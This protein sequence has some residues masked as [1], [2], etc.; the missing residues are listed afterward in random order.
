MEGR[1]RIELFGQL[2]VGRGDAAPLPLPR[3][4]ATALLAYLAYHTRHPHAR[5]GL[6]DLLWPEADLEEGR[7]NLRRQLH[8]LRELLA[9]PES[10]AGALLL[11]ERTTVQLDPAMFTTDVAEFHAALRAAAR[12]ADLT[13]RLRALEAA[14]TLYRGELLP[15]SYEG[16]V[17]TERQALAERYLGALRELAA[18]REAA[19]DLEGALATAREA[20]SSDPLQEEAHYDVMRLCAALGQPTA[21]LRQ[22][23]ELERVLREEL[24]E[25]PSAEAR[26]LAEELR[27]SARTL[28]VARRSSPLLSPALPAAAPPPGEPPEAAPPPRG[29]PAPRLPAQ[30]TRFFGREEETAWLVELLAAGGTRL[31]TLTGP[32]G[33]G[34]TRLAIAVA[35][36]LEALFDEA[37]AVASLVDLG[38]AGRLMETIADALELPRSPEVEP[39][40]QVVAHLQGRPWLLVLDNF[41][42]LVEGGATQVRT[43][44][45]QVESLVCLVTS[46]Q[47]LGLSGERELALLPLPT[48]RRSDP[49]E[50]VREYASVQLFGDRARAVRADFQLTEANASAVGEL[51]DR[52]EGLPLALELAG[53][54]AA[55]LSP[56]EMLG[57]LE[58]RFAFLVSRRRDVS[59]RHR[60][61]RAAIE[62]SYQLLDPE[63]RQFFAR[64]SVFRGGFT[65]EAAHAVCPSGAGAG[66]DPIRAPAAGRRT[67]VEYLEQLRECSL[68]GVEE[69]S[70]ASRYRLLE[71][72]REYG[73]EQLA[74]AGELA[75]T[76][77]RHREWYLQLAEQADAEAYELEVMPKGWLT[78][79]EAELENLRAALGWC[80]EEAE[81]NPA[82]EGAEAGLRLA[83]A[84]C[85][86]WSGRGNLT[87]G[88]QWLEA[89]LARGSHLPASVRGP[90]LLRAA[91]LERRGRERW[92]SFVQAARREYEQVLNL[93][94]R[95]GNLSDIAHSLQ[96]LAEVASDDEDFEAAWSYC[97]EARQLFDE[98]GEPVGIARTLGWMAGIALRRGELRAA[99][100][101]LE[102]R[103]AICRTLGDPTLLVHALGGMGHLERNE[104]DYAC[105]Q[106]LYQ[107][108][109]LLRR[110]LGALF[111]LAQSLED[112][113]VLAGRQRQTER[114]IRLL[115]AAEA[116]CETLGA[117][118]PVAEPAEYERTVTEGRAVLGEAVF[119]AV[120]AAGRVM[121][122]EQAIEYALE[123]PP[124]D[125]SPS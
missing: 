33:S 35:G 3:Q 105:A 75:A 44:L 24:A 47:V 38:D 106:A 59:P 101:L 110:E 115:G 22:Y 57:E 4:K 26:A 6:I 98:L 91:H 104:G 30:L 66:S 9:G 31:V 73:W 120:W 72:L 36:R 123:D 1:W 32:G 39:F 56:Q 99:R 117:R 42:Q 34:K 70:G 118:P 93:A 64:L 119:A 86:L 10:D 90:A 8:L 124:G 125:T 83:A 100:P 45:E 40:V 46:R 79:L 102:E 61:L 60:T 15:G 29:H 19:G 114:A 116:F 27:Q 14:V 78:R 65:L 89:M 112:L 103:L 49:L 111:A 11:A 71:T 94:R 82:G 55:V 13:E 50:R 88:L 80:Q 122:L 96:S 62:S 77:S 69:R 17:L 109:L 41:E 63:L 28:V 5:E 16:W 2:R 81:A 95:E 97:V 113:A 18:A 53:A 48:P 92:R 107:E 43:L 21:A 58:E 52:L 51:C 37:V 121:S 108:S 12:A 25:T 87:E 7:H 54:R 23:Q 76:R 68:I 74:A 84:L 67:T 85:G 20:V